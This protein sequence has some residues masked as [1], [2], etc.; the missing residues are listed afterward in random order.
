[1]RARNV[2][3]DQTSTN[4]PFFF[5]RTAADTLFVDRPDE[6]LAAGTDPESDGAV[7]SKPSAA[8]MDDPIFP[9]AN[10]AAFLQLQ[11][12]RPAVELVRTGPHTDANCLDDCDIVASLLHVRCHGYHTGFVA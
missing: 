10:D 12:V 6:L 3:F 1:M 8:V 9:A 2:T 7:S 11:Q 5:V 4:Q